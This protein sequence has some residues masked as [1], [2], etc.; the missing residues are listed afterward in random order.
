MSNNIT[1]IG[2]DSQNNKY[3]CT[4]NGGLIYIVN[5]ILQNYTILN[6]GVPDN[7]VATVQ[8]DELGKPWYASPAQGLF[9]DTGNQT[10]LLQNSSNSGLASNS[11]TTM[12]IDD[13]QNFYLGTHQNGLSVKRYNSLWEN[14]TISNSGIP[15][16]HILSLAKD[17]NNYIWIGTYSKGLVRLLEGQLDLKQV[18]K[19]EK[20]EVYPNPAQSSDQLNFN[21]I[22]IHPTIQIFSSEGKL[23]SSK[24]EDKNIS[25]A[26]L[27]LL[28]SG[29]YILKIIE[30]DKVENV[31]LVLF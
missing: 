19:D 9:T 4:I 23:I 30:N 1:S 24:K 3:I 6:A 26:T 5:G 28:N 15:E 11:L 8:I 17:S 25:N 22:L 18:Q 13:S 2:I 21:R 12:I 27:P 16:N 7:S 29:N 14:Y 31:H 20:I 10:W